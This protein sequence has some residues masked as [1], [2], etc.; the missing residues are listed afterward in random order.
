MS[1]KRK[2]PPTKLQES[3]AAGGVHL[4]VATATSEG[5]TGDGGGGTLSDQEDANS[6]TSAEEPIQNAPANSGFPIGPT[7]PTS[8]ARELKGL[9]NNN[10]SINN[11]KRSMDDVL[12]MLSSKIRSDV[13]VAAGEGFITEA[14]SG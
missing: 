14:G 10:S 12:K 2:S 13:M 11:N 6:T 8:P 4:L 9:N 7:S 3:L 5:G 1:S